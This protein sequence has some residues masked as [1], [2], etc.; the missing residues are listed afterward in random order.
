MCVDAESISVVESEDP[1]RQ[2]LISPLL[3]VSA[4]GDHVDGLEEV[5]RETVEEFSGHIFKTVGHLWLKDA[6]GELYGVL[7]DV[8]YD[9]YLGVL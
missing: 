7:A 5:I 8:E 9:L 3:A 4:L 2:K 1:V 6:E